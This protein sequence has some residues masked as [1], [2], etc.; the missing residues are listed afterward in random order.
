MSSGKLLLAIGLAALPALAA[1]SKG[2]KNEKSE[3][4]E[5]PV[6]STAAGGEVKPGPGGKVITI[7]L[8]SDEKSNR[9]S[10]NEI[11]AHQGDVLR[12]TLKVGVHNVD[13]LPDSN[14]GKAGLPKASDMLQLPG[15]TFDVAV[16]FAPG[17]YYFQCDPH[18]LLG[19]HGHV[20]V[21]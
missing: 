7:E 4:A 6:A 11:E 15:Q 12:Y 10:P 20:K 9:F 1:C 19:M 5:T 16:N 3:T 18:S 8:I 2:E 21:E 13:F 14:P 17:T